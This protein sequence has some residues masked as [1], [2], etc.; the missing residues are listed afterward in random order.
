MASESWPGGVWALG[1]KSR[2]S[3]RHITYLGS[4]GYIS[5]HPIQLT[6][7]IVEKIQALEIRII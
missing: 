7:I 6:H 4:V 1:M 3:Q 5:H 2:V